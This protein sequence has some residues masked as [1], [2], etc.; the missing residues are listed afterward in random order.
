MDNICGAA[1]PNCRTPNSAFFTLR[2]KDRR[3]H[4]NSDRTLKLAFKLLFIDALSAFSAVVIGQKLRQ[5]NA[6]S[7]I[8]WQLWAHVRQQPDNRSSKPASTKQP[9]SD[10][11]ASI[12][13]NSC[14]S[15][16]PR[17]V[18]QHQS[19]RRGGPGHHCHKKPP[20]PK[21]KLKPIQ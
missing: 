3:N 5:C 17:G 2:L 6:T 15:V 18:S 12:P 10:N 1:L 20:N 9:R 21:P 13:P 19:H 14:L 4:T 11:H 7:T 16:P 8:I